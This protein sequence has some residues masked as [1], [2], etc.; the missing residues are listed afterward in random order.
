MAAAPHALPLGGA[1]QP[2][3]LSAGAVASRAY[4]AHWHRLFLRNMLRDVSSSARESA[5]RLKLRPPQ[6]SAAALAPASAAGAAAGSAAGGASS[7][8]AAAGGERPRSKK[9]AGPLASF[10]V[11]TKEERE[12][13]QRAE[14]AKDEQR[15]V[16]REQA[17]RELASDVNRAELVRRFAAASKA[18]GLRGSP[19]EDSVS[20]TA[21]ALQMYI[22]DLIVRLVAAKNLR[23]DARKQTALVAP[24]SNP[25]VA[26]AQLEWQLGLRR[27]GKGADGEAIGAD[28]ASAMGERKRDEAGGVAGAS[29]SSSA[30]GAGAGASGAAAPAALSAED[31]EALQLQRGSVAANAMRDEA[32]DPKRSSIAMLKSAAEPSVT[33]FDVIT[34]LESRR[35]TAKSERLYKIYLRLAPHN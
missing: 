12:V 29:A 24:T 28:G 5:R 7:S 3:S 1:G 19:A 4:E 27:Q 6:D 32:E 14:L 33:I 17:M 16:S 13:A 35:R 8:S 31:S 18:A 21:Q 26:L 23:L 22:R 20:L 9:A 11:N 34:V 15:T 10:G 25:V 30:S 2:P